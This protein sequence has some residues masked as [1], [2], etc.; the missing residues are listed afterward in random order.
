MKKS[1]SILL[2]RFGFGWLERLL[3]PV[4][5]ALDQPFPRRIAVFNQVLQDK[6]YIDTFLSE[7]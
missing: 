2:D 5:D 4:D 1:S 6:K 7:R 3:E